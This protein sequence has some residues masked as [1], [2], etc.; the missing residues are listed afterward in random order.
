VAVSLDQNTNLLTFLFTDIESSTRLWEQFPQEMKVSLER[1]DA[2]LRAA[3][4][5]SHGRVVKSTGDGMMAVFSSTNEAVIACQKAQQNLLDEPWTETGPL[6]VRMGLHVGEAQTRAD[7]YFGPVINRT[8]RLMSAAHGSQV[9]LSGAAASLVVD[10][11]P[12]GTSLL[13]LGEHRLKDLERPEHIFQLVSP[14]LE[15]DFPPLVTLDNR[16]NNLPAQP[17]P[18]IGRESELSEIISRLSSKDVR[19]L[20]LTGPGGIGKTRIS[21]QAGAELIEQFD[22]VYFVDLAPITD[23]ESVPLAVA[24]SIGFRETSDRSPLEDL[25]A[26]LQAK[27]FL[28]LFDNFEQ[29]TSAAPI[30]AELLR[31]CPR[32]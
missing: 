1:H 19:L 6:R 16:P 13:D 17:T 8:A 22:G 5:S 15:S 18:L 30:V 23:P 31:D 32:L 26:Q 24:Q 11:M 2:L 12:E 20:T 27:S 9:L 28:I 3:V 29:V 25:K 14:G 10:R 7:D 21:L 4:E